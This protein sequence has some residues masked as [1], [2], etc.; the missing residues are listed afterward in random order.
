MV[1]QTVLK[2]RLQAVFMLQQNLIPK[3]YS[4]IK[5]RRKIEALE[6]T[7]GSRLPTPL[8][9]PTD[10]PGKENFLGIYVGWQHPVK[11]EAFYLL[12]SP[13]GGEVIHYE[14]KTVRIYWSKSLAELKFER[15]DLYA[16][17][18]M[19]L[20]TI[21]RMRAKYDRLYALT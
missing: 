7:I 5:T 6:Q 19:F 1:V 13:A 8:I 2:R 11:F 20:K 10:Y 14:N 15:P 9:L 4:Y 12:I 3:Q 18:V 17:I 21:S 16:T